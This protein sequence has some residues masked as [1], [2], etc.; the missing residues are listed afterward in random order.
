MSQ[1]FVAAAAALAPQIRLARDELESGRRLPS[2]LAQALNQ[3]GLLQL[4]LPRS[5]GGPEVDPITA[6]LAIEE[7]SKADGSVGW[8]AFLSSVGATYAAHLRPEL[9]RE[10]F[11]QPPD[12][13]MA[14]SFRPDGEARPVDG[15]YCV[16]GRWAYA[17]GI[18]HANWLNINCKVMDGEVPCLTPA[19]TP[20][21]RMALVPAEAATVHDTWFSVGMCGTGS[22]D[23]AMKEVFVPEERTFVLFGPPKEDGPL[24]NPRFFIVAVWTPVAANALGMARG[25]MDS[26][27]ELS[28]RAGTTNSAKLL[29]DRAQVQTT[30]GEAEAITSGARAYVLEAVGTAWRAFCEGAPDP[31]HEIA[32]ARLAITHAMWEAVRA[33]DLLFHA[34]GTNAIHQRHPLER[35]FRDIHVA[36][37][38]GAGLRSN[39]ES[40]GQVLLGL[41]PQDHGW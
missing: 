21:T 16:N 29:R 18:D 5:M 35:F 41:Q 13:R 8:C 14:G 6:F 26:F 38:H 4:N 7:L 17:S 22:N 9:G 15:G 2:A 33:V 19:G 12:F 10:M 25:A 1:D 39:F 28:S 30:V 3:A 23:F 31:R 20:E 34:A 24:Y 32:Q 40:A 11:G 27:V 36:A 37:Q